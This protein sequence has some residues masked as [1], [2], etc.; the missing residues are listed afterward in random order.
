MQLYFYNRSHVYTGFG[1]E[2]RD[3]EFVSS[4]Y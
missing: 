1:Y 4:F 2:I 3:I